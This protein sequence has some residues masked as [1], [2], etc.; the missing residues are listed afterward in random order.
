[1]KRTLIFGTLLLLFLTSSVQ[2]TER[3]ADRSLLDFPILFAK[4]FNYQWLHIYDTFYQWRPGG[5]I[6]VLENPA[7]PPE[8]HRVIPVGQ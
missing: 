7:D 4:R 6:Y 2:A 3:I 8:Q 5:G 1:M